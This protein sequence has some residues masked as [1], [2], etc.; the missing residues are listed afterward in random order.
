MK[1]N[2]QTGTLF[3]HYVAVV[4]R[5]RNECPWDREQTHQ[6]IRHSLLEEAYE[7]IE[8]IDHND[9]EELKQELGDLLLHVALHSVMAEQESAFTMNDVILATTEKMIRRHPHV[10][11]D[12][13]V[14]SA[15]EVKVNWEKLKMK[16]GRRSVLDGV[17][18]ELPAL[19]RAG[20]IQEKAS[21]VGFDWKETKDVW[22]KVSEEIQELESARERDKEEELGDV[23][24]SLVNYARFLNMNPELAL[25]KT[26]EK[27]IRRFH[28]IEQELTG[29]GKKPEDVTLEELD[30][31]WNEGKRL[32]K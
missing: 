32:G 20:R 26:T 29:K 18:K 6:S 14:S 15:H 13:K 21:K 10:F 22:N 19:L 4:R 9:M 16:E 17:P 23:L 25:K 7:V 28:H 2:H 27:F 31:L 24:F 1:A 3:E 8:A 11:S 30:G 5:L 12:T